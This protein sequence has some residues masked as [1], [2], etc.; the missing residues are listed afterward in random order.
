M[1]KIVTPPLI[2]GFGLSDEDVVQIMVGGKEVESWRV[3]YLIRSLDL[4]REIVCD[5]GAQ[6]GF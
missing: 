6:A 5:R 4:T 3:R 2:N 1:C